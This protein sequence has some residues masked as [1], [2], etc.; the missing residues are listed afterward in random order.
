MKLLKRLFR[1][2][3]G[4]TAVE[5]GIMV[6]AIAAVIVTVVFLIGEEIQAAFQTVLDALLGAGGGAEVL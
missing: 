3:E 1:E 4:A 6:A 5:Y 2:E